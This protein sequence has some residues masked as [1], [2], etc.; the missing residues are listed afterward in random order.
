MA[1]VQNGTRPVLLFF[2]IIPWNL[3]PKILLSFFP[4]LE[5]RQ[6]RGHDLAPLGGDSGSQIVLPKHL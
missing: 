6:E 4:E 3:W 1:F 5:T 2:T